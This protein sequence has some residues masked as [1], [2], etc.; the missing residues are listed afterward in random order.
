MKRSRREYLKEIK[1]EAEERGTPVFIVD[2]NKLKENYA[3]FKKRLPHIRIYYAVKANPDPGI[4]KTLYDMGSSFDVASIEEFNLVV[5]NIKTLS[6]QEQKEWIESNIIYANPIKPV[7]TLERLNEYN[8]LVT[9]DNKEEIKKIKVH[10]PQARLCLRIRVPNTGSMS[11]LSSKFGA[12]PAEA[13]DLILKAKA[14]KLDV[15]GISFH[16]GSQCN[17]FENYI[18][19]L[20]ITSEIFKESKS[21]GHELK[22]VD[23]GG[24]F[25]YRYNNTVKPFKM[26][27][28]EL[29]DDI[30]RLFPKN[31]EI[32]AEPGRFMVANSA[33]LVAKVIGKSVRDGRT[34]YYLDDGI[35]HTFS[36]EIFDHCVYP[37]QSFKRGKKK[38]SVVF[39]PTC[40]AF[41]KISS[42]AELPELKI[43]DLVYAENIGAYS[44]ATSS[45]FNGFPP[46][47]VAHLDLE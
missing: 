15:K 34:C 38:V 2:H 14:L 22:L 36:G 20:Q 8:P 11:E 41:D 23:I 30:K 7:E 13:V 44:L 3:E 9:F 4:V 31:I 24:G 47:R 17:N 10:C 35:Y 21:R 25:P 37:L 40:D 39:G 18:Q 5:E 12:D 19:A 45:H 33:V 1:Q 43:G 26:L 27:A 46:A 32:L 16:V 6:A 29:K 28:K 42:A